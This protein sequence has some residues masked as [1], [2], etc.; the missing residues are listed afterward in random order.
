MA[1]PSCSGKR[2]L[3]VED[4]FVLAESLA[5]LLESAGCEVAGVAG[6]IHTALTLVNEV[7]FD[8][9][10]LDIHLHGKPV[11]AEILFAAIAQAL[12]GQTG[13]SSASRNGQ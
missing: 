7:P 9:A 1:T 13:A 2:V 11:P 10:L 8:I 5:C 6:E 4:N 3:V 12:E